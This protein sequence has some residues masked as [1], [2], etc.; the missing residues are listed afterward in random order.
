MFENGMLTWIDEQ[1]SILLDFP[2]PQDLIEYILGIENARDLE[3][4]LKTLLDF[5]NPNHRRFLT[6]LIRRRQTG[7]H[8]LGEGRSSVPS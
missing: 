5:N 8:R 6:E 1:L 3:D 7:T 2:V 4:Y